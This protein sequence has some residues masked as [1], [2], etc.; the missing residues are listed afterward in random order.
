MGTTS[1]GLMKVWPSLVQNLEPLMKDVTG[2]KGV[3]LIEMHL[4]RHLKRHAEEL[5]VAG[6]ASKQQVTMTHRS[7]RLKWDRFFTEMRDVRCEVSLENAMDFRPPNKILALGSPEEV[8]VAVRPW[9]N[10]MQVTSTNKNCYE[11]IHSAYIVHLF[12][13]YSTANRR[14]ANP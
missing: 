10:F 4:K 14:N 9:K 5:V 6:H 11:I 12:T 8:V 2:V 7:A 1:L 13:G 3:K